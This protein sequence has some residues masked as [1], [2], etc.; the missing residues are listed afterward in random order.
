[1]GTV[2]SAFPLFLL[3]S[4]G[5]HGYHSTEVE[6]ARK[7]SK[8]ESG[9]L[10]HPGSWRPL[11]AWW[12]G[13]GSVTAQPYFPSLAQGPWDSPLGLFS[14]PAP[15][16]VTGSRVTKE[17]A[18]S[19]FLLVLSRRLFRP[20]RLHCTELAIF[21]VLTQVELKFPALPAGPCAQA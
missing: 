5:C 21:C 13:S 15:A 11:E 12:V 8:S 7:S 1:M 4:L 17:V 19:Y 16:M 10:D 14:S 6:D 18:E 9:P 20:L 3:G 2:G